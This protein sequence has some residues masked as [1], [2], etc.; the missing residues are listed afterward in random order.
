MSEPQSRLVQIQERFENILSS[1]LPI[2]HESRQLI[3]DHERLL[4]IAEQAEA[5]LAA[6]RAEWDP[7]HSHRIT[8]QQ[9][10][11]ADGRLGPWA[12]WNQNAWDE[13][14]VSALQALTAALGAGEPGA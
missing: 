6:L 2:P 4:D 11:D 12:A 8:V 13:G 7:L 9:I 14:T 5:L 1:D 10:K 3:A